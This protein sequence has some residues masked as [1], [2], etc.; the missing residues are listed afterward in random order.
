MSLIRDDYAIRQKVRTKATSSSLNRPAVQILS[1][2][3]P[4]AA[5]SMTMARCVGVKQT[6]SQ[7]AEAVSK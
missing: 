1:K 2:S 3:S 5:Y 6:C 7:Q 4:P